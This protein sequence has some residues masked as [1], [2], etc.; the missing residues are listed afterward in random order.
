MRRLLPFYLINTHQYTTFKYDRD[1]LLIKYT[2][3]THQVEMK[4]MKK[5][6]ITNDLEDIKMSINNKKRLDAI[7]YGIYSHNLRLY[8]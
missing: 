4:K 5:S 3:N 8:V 7:K 1:L 6:R 2:P